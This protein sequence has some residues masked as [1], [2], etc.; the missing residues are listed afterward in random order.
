MR[1]Q[2]TSSFFV[3]DLKIIA[4]EDDVVNGDKEYFGSD[5]K[6]EHRSDLKPLFEL[7]NEVEDTP[8]LVG[9]ELENLVEEIM[10]RD[11]HNS[12]L[13]ISLC[14]NEERFDMSKHPNLTITILDKYES[15]SLAGGKE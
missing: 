12:D 8:T 10:Q 7:H 13:C 4:K 5:P 9:C 14:H 1:G 11:V 3:G 2:I 6:E 15:S